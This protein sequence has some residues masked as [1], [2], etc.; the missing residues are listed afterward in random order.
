MAK[1]FISLWSNPQF[2]IAQLGGFLSEKI[3]ADMWQSTQIKDK[4]DKKN[5]N[6]HRSKTVKIIIV[7]NSK[8]KEEKTKINQK[9]P[10]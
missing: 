6:I 3:A 4:Q 7:T 2:C 5:K 10:H 8:L 1:G 9:N